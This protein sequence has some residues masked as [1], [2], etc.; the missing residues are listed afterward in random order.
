MRVMR[1]K[2]EITLTTVMMASRKNR[3]PI[4]RASSR[5]SQLTHWMQRPKNLRNRKKRRNVNASVIKKKKRNESE[6]GP[7][8]K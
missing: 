7:N 4:L 6:K 2:W 1:I 5:F 3:T 8:L